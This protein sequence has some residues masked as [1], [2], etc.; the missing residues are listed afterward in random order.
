MAKGNNYT[1]VVKKQTQT[2]EGLKL[3]ADVVETYVPIMSGSKFVGAFEIYFDIT[4]RKK[5]IDDLISHSHNII[6]VIA[7]GLLAAVVIS[8]LRA[9]VNIEERNRAEEQLRKQSAELKETNS[10]LLAF[11]EVSSAIS[12]TMDMNELLSIVL[13]TVTGLGVLNIERKGGIFIIEGDKMKLVSHLGHS[14]AFLDLHKDMKIGD[15]LC[16]IVAETGEILISENSAEDIRHTIVYPDA[17]PHGHIIVPLKAINKL[18]GVL[19]LYLAPDFKID[20]RKVKMLVSLGNQIGMAIDNARLYE[21]T[22][23]L[24]LQDPLTGLA[25]RR[26]M[27]IV[28]DRSFTRAKRYGHLLS[29]IMLD[30]DYFKKYN[31]TYG[32]SAGDQLLVDIAKIISG[33]MREVDVIVRYGGEEFLVMLPETEAEKAREAAERIRKAVE[34]KVGVTVSLGVASYNK[35]MQT[36]EDLIN[37]ADMALYLAKQNGRNRVEMI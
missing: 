6:F 7:A 17:V 22:K 30:I 25:N 5:K 21:E 9:R 19:Y 31:D 2:L 24:S 20:E 16:G 37:R 18:A 3:S 33:E 36:K 35:E 11:Y 29:V 28:M 4:E 26:F 10:E 15:C 23:S 8:S 27:E 12:R 14:K 13:N 32:H 1:K 34:S